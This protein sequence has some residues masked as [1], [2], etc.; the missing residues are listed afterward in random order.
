M[1]KKIGNYLKDSKAELQKVIWPSR[2]QTKNHTLL[3]IGISLAVA[4]F[5]GVVDLILNKILELFVY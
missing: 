1:F 3:V 2:Q 5:L 4:V